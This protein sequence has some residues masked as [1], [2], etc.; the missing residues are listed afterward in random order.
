MSTFTFAPAFVYL[1]HLSTP[2]NARHPAQHY[3]GTTLD[4]AARDTL[5]QSGR[6]ARL[7]SVARERGITFQ[8]VRVWPG[9]R[10]LER[11][12]KRCGHA[13]RYCPVCSGVAAFRRGSVPSHEQLAFD[14]EELPDA[15]TIKLDWLELTIEREFR[16]QRRPAPIDLELIDACL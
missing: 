14:L 9:D 8:I 2:V 11:Q 4:L 7:L 15:P 1:Y 13:S 10:A 16:A 6:G 5:H 3:I 12:L